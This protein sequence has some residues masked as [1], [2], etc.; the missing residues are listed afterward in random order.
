MTSTGLN[1]KSLISAGLVKGIDYETVLVN[2]K[3]HAGYYPGSV[4]ITL[5]LIF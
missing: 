4:P 3:S 2:Q 1:E 5:K